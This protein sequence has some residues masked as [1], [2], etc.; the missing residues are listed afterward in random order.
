MCGA[1]T[2]GVAIRCMVELCYYKGGVLLQ[3]QVGVVIIGYIGRWGWVVT[4]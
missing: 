2:G 4:L 3:K 1:I